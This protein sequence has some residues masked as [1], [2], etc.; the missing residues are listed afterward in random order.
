LPQPG[1]YD[2]IIIGAGSAGCVLANRLSADPGTSVLLLE[3]GGWDRN[4]LLHVP[5]AWI[6]ILE[7][8][9]HDWDYFMQAQAGMDGRAIECARG[10]VIGGCSSTNAMLYVRGHPKDYDAWAAT[11]LPGWDYPSVLPFFRQQEHW[12][13]GAD[14]WRGQQGPLQTMRCGYEDPVIPAFAECAAEAGHA[15]LADYNAATPEGFSRMQFTIGEG[16]RCSAA[17]AFLHPVRHRPNLKVLTGCEVTGIRMEGR[18]AV[19]VDCLV[20]KQPQFLRAEREVLCSAGVINSPKLLMLSG[21]GEAKQLE[22]FGIPVLADLPGVGKNLQDHLSVLAACERTDRGP[23]HRQMRLDRAVRNMLGAMLFGRGFATEQPAGHLGFLRSNPGQDLP[24]IQLMFNA[25]PI[26]ARPWLPPASKSFTDGFGCRVVLVRPQS[27]GQVRLASKDPRSAPLIEG[28]FLAEATDLE[29]LAAGL[30]QAND[31]LSRAPLSAYR[32]ALRTP[33]GNSATLQDYIRRTA[34]TVHHPMGSCRM[35]PAADTQAVTD[36]AFRVHGVEG[37]R[38]ID[39]SVIPVGIGGNINAP[40]MMLA[41]KAATLLSGRPISGPAHS[42][43][44]PRYAR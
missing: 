31:L 22:E 42:P 24:D 1:S 19:G 38:V 15:L 35:G 29:R 16:R 44:N 32:K 4:P 6:K 23:F 43:T 21:I 3:A 10:K 8:R 30:E 17:R 25:A 12:Q 28:N 20:E 39:A 34:I 18:C 11:G 5:I 40:V 13:H 7:Q 41:E 14:N 33:A 27:R 36:A 9:W 26:T 37:L 2:Y